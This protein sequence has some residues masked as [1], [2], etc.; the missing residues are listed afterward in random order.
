MLHLLPG[1]FIFA[2][3]PRPFS[4]SHVK[5]IFIDLLYYK[6]NKRKIESHETNLFALMIPS[7]L[8]FTVLTTSCK[9]KIFE[10]TF[11]KFFYCVVPENIHTPP[12]KGVLV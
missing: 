12:M 4:G 1:I 10:Q 3:I 2:F 8:D 6:L 9:L 7:S 5:I 11:N